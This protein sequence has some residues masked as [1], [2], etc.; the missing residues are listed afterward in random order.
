ML[1]AVTRIPSSR[2]VATDEAYFWRQVATDEAYFWRPI[3][4]RVKSP[5]MG[6]ASVQSLARV[7]IGSRAEAQPKEAE[8]HYGTCTR[9]VSAINAHTF[10]PKTERHLGKSLEVILTLVYSF[11][12]H[13]FW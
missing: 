12:F 9:S 2:K 10:R 3:R 13:R 5:N 4:G 6:S 7:L 8:K 1:T 11:L